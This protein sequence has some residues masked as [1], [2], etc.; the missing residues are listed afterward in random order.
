MWLGDPS[1]RG[2]RAPTPSARQLVAIRS[3]LLVGV[4]LFGLVAWWTHRRNGGP[5]GGAIE[6]LRVVGPMLAVSAVAAAFVF[7]SIIGRTADAAQRAGLRVVA[8]AVGEGASLA[9][10]V[11]YFQ[12]GDAR[13]FAVGV[14]A[15]LASFAIVPAQDGE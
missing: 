5:A 15:M 8:W 6:A 13:F 10:T 4:L 9:C 7:R 3:A 1:T 2:G 12:A 14:A 11:Y